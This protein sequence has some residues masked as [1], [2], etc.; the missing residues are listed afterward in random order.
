MMK[1]ILFILFTAIFTMAAVTTNP[2]KTGIGGGNS[3]ISPGAADW[4]VYIGDFTDNVVVTASGPMYFGGINLHGATSGT[5]VSSFQSNAVIDSESFGI[6]A[7]NLPSAAGYYS[8]QADPEAWKT[9]VAT[10]R[11][12][13]RV[14]YEDVPVSGGEDYYHFIGGTSGNGLALAATNYS[15][16]GIQLAENATNF[17]VRTHNG[18]AAVTHDTGVAFAADTWF[19][20]EIEISASATK[21]WID[22]VQVLSAGAVPAAETTMVLIPLLGVRVGSPSAVRSIYYD[23]AYLAYKN[24]NGR[25]STS[26]GGPF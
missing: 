25:G 24:P 15:V 23:W 19:N 17:V 18:T 6:R 20:L 8:L 16:L 10:V 1:Q 22:G 5:G 3:T 21:A 26:S 9:G 4:A 11:M 7:F 13:V 2:T 14:K 12:G